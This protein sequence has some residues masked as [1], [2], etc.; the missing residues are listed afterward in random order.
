[1]RFKYLF[2]Q[3]NSG[4]GKIDTRWPRHTRSEEQIR[5]DISNFINEENDM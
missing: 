4:F 1:M 2:L 3:E 5:R